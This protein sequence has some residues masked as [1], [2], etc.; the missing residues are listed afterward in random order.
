MDARRGSRT[1]TRPRFWKVGLFVG[2]GVL[3]IA[4]FVFTNQMLTRL[5]HQVE[6]TSRI[7]AT[8]CAQASIPATRDTTLTK[9]FKDVV[10]QIDFPIVITD[11]L[12][13]PRAW[14]GIGIDQGLVPDGAVDSLALSYPIGAGSRAVIDRVRARAVQLDAKNSP[15][16]MS[17]PGTMVRLGAV[18]YGDPP[19]L[20]RLRWMPLLSVLGV[21]LLLSL[22]LWGL[23][24]IRTAEK[25]TIW[26]GMAKESAHQMGTPLSS[27]L[28]WVELMRSHAEGVA[29][30]GDVR[31]PAAEFDETLSE[32]QRDVD[33]LSKVAQRFSHIGSTPILQL[34][35]VTPVVREAVQYVRKR[36]PHGAH[37]IEI[38]ERYDEA[39]P[40]N[41]NRELLEWVLENVLSNAVSAIE[42]GHGRIDVSV[43]RRA[44]TE[45]VEVVITD[46]GRGMAPHEQR[47]AFEAGYTT[48]A[49][50]WGLGLALARRVVQ[51]YH[52]GKI[53]IRASAPGE[54]TTIVIGFPT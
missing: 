42:R 35:D 22:G 15:I 34:Q 39:P 53:T 36:L 21:L 37:S 51:D 8:F 32:M 46:N 54:G 48:K 4:V 7:F 12:G 45:E 14:R 28:G 27:L 13:L 30:G 24:G 3:V 23:T 52:G 19:V 44:E 41:L 9:I 1:F 49:R 50:G 20:D 10:N 33:R 43:G 25:R 40:V 2:T 17:Q 31:I 18:H 26:V 47:R 38:H 6:T 16:E 11:T 29:A 5:T